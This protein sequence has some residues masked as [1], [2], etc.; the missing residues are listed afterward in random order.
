MIALVAAVA[1]V[2]CATRAEPSPPMPTSTNWVIAGP[3]SWGIKHNNIG[4]TRNGEHFK[5]AGVSVDAG[6]DVTVRVLTRGAAL[7]YKRSRRVPTVANSHRALR[8]RPCDPDTPSFSEKGTTVGLRT[9]FAGGV[10]VD[11][12][13]CVRVRVTRGGR[14]WIAFL[15]VGK[16]LRCGATIEELPEGSSA[17]R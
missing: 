1:V 4:R 3:I 8:F 13:K 9:G 5:K 7:V 11:R 2:G 17:I 12:E 10:I 14:S 6:E 16:R 15:P